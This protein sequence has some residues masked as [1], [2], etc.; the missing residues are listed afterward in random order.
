MRKYIS[1]E[2]MMLFEPNIY[3]QL[4]ARISG[5]LSGND[6]IIAVKA[7]FANNEVTMSKIV[8]HT[9]GTAFYEKMDDSGCSVTVTHKHWTDIVN[10]N[11]KLP[12]NIHQGELMR[13]FITPS[14]EG[15]SLLMMAH[16]LVGDGK[17]IIYFLEDILKALSGENP[18]YKPLRLATDSDFPKESI[19]P[20]GYK[21]YADVYNQQWSKSGRNVGWADYFSIHGSYWRK[22]SSRIIYET[23]SSDEINGISVRAKEAGVTI[24]SYIINA[25][26]KADRGNSRIA[27][28]VNARTSH[29]QSMSNQVA[30]ISIRHR[31]SARKTFEENAKLIHQ[32]IYKEIN[33]PIKKFFN[34]QFVPLFDPALLDSIFLHIYNKYANKTTAKLAK[35]IGYKGREKKDLGFTNLTKI[36][37]A[38]NKSSSYKISQVL[39]VAPMI[40]YVKRIVCIYTLEDEMTIS[41]RIMNAKNEAKERRFFLRAIKNIRVTT[42][43]YTHIPKV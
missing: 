15:I 16:H 14:D 6:L 27:V 4:L 31:Y 32:K 36:D 28:A 20:P 26:L 35:I 39:I 38:Y 34:L 11:E 1:S 30:G 9:D 3:I 40:S 29:N 24:N 2:R 19:L 43:G 13:V 12:F 8:L 42:A 7:A 37:I 22:H 10:E 33:D 5:N 21:E 41:Y 17:A 18:E 23:F 25:F